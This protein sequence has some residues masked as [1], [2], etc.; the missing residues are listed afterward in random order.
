LGAVVFLGPTGATARL[1]EVSPSRNLLARLGVL[2]STL[3]DVPPAVRV[4]RL[5][6]MLRATRCLLLQQGDPDS[7]ADV[8]EHGVLSS[9]H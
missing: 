5:A 6:G 7:T 2:R 1:E 8:L 3:W 4:M 9:C